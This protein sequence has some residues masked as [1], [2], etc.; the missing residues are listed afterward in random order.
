MSGEAV[1]GTRW[2]KLAACGAQP[3]PCRPDLILQGM[4]RH[5]AHAVLQ[6]RGCTV[7]EILGGVEEHRQAILAAGGLAVV[8]D[9]LA[10]H[11]AGATGLLLSS[12]HFG[13][14]QACF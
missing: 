5:P 7:L 6:Q 14:F 11:P 2:R 9:A 8:T 13:R 10:R 3:P 1:D 4:R 12:C